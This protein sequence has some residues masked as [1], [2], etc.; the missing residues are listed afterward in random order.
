[1]WKK[2]KIQQPAAQEPAPQ[3]DLLMQIR[4]DQLRQQ[5]EAN[6]AIQALS[7][8]QEITAAMI[9]AA[10]DKRRNTDIYTGLVS[11]MMNMK[12]Q[13]ASNIINNMRK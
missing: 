4:A 7:D 8:E 5:E 12:H 9:Q 13:T 6:E 11:T 1:M 3:L 10:I 2:R